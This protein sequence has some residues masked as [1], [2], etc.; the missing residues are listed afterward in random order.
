MITSTC[1]GQLPVENE[2]DSEYNAEFQQARHVFH[3]AYFEKASIL[4]DGLL[5]R[6]KIMP[7]PMPMPLWQ[8]LCFT[9]TLQLMLT[10]QKS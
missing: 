3:R 7:W 8:I 6:N 4:I 10:K 5:L 1:L 2:N 9:K